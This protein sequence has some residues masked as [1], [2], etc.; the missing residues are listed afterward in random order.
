MQR[1]C[2]RCLRRR[3]QQRDRLRAVADRVIALA[4]Q[5][6]GNTGLFYSYSTD[7]G[8][9]WSQSVRIP[10]PGL[11]NNVFAWAAAGSDGRVDV[12]WYGTY[13]GVDTVTGPI[14]AHESR[15]ITD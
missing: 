7:E 3:Q 1:Q 14:E 11:R 12:A 15:R 10:T 9:T 13:A 4:E 8:N 6:V 5:P 2:G